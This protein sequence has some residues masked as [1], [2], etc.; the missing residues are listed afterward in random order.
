MYV[1][2]YGTSVDY[3][4]GVEL[5]LKAAKQGH[6]MAQLDLGAA[7]YNGKGIINDSVEAYA[8]FYLASMK[9]IEASYKYKSAVYNALLP[10]DKIRAN[11]LVDE[12]TK[13]YK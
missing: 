5:F 2:G 12:Y 11:K 13:I 6:G 7:Y 4:K 8:W 10:E 9:G 3:K 1:N